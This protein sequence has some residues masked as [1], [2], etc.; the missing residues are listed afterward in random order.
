MEPSSHDAPSI[1]SGGVCMSIKYCLLSIVIKVRKIN[2]YIY[3][4]A[5]VLPKR[6]LFMAG[7]N[8][9]DTL[10]KVRFLK[11]PSVGKSEKEQ[12]DVR[13]LGLGLGWVPE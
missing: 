1:A 12:K 11:S 3:L 8:T 9:F 4:A 7:F 5:L 2:M 13:K 6:L 10:M